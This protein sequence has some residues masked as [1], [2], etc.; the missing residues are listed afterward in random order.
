[1]WLAELDINDDRDKLP[2]IENG[3]TI[4]LIVGA[5]DGA[6]RAFEVDISWDGDPKLTA[7]EVLASALGRLAVRAA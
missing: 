3:Y 5:D 1:L 7:N 6:G 2:P 4:R